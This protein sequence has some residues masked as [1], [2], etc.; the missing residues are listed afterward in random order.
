M[1]Q[2]KE[3]LKLPLSFLEYPGGYSRRYET[4]GKSVETQK[5]IQSVE[6]KSKQ[7]EKIDGLSLESI[8]SAASEE[9]KERKEI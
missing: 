4:E 6:V 7:S 9:Q 2:Q 8:Q 1:S 3:P 5:T